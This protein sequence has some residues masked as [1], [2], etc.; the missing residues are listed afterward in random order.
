MAAPRRAG[1]LGG[2]ACGAGGG[3]YLLLACSPKRQPRVRSALEA[4]GG[5]FADFA[6]VCAHPA[7]AP[8]PQKYVEA[9][10]DASGTTVAFGDMP[11]GNGPFKMA[12]P[13]KH[14][15]FIKVVKNDKATINQQMQVALGKIAFLPFGLLVGARPRGPVPEQGQDRRRYPPSARSPGAGSHSHLRCRSPRTRPPSSR[16]CRPPANESGPSMVERPR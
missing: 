9:G 6:F 1:A 16:A 5:A 14:N 10:V 11:I 7:L 13:W 15:Q 4:Q 12:E 2:K 8:V 3:G